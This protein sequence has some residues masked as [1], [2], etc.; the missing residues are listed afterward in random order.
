[1][2]EKDEIIEI[3]KK[4]FGENSDEIFY[5]VQNFFRYTRKGEIA[6]FEDFVAFFLGHHCGEITV[7]RFHRGGRYS[8]GGERIMS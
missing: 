4:I 2:A 6:T 7:Q 3:L 8:R 1:M 5:V